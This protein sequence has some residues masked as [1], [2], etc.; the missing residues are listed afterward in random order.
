MS[1]GRSTVYKPEN[2]GVGR[3][4][5]MQGATNDTLRPT[6]WSRR[7][8][9]WH[10]AISVPRLWGAEIPSRMI[11]NSLRSLTNSL[12]TRGISAWGLSEVSIMK[13]Q[14]LDQ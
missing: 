1:G 3:L 5:C 10:R 12:A 9:P 13:L 6:P 4:A 11:V 8:A 2:A 14:G 7:D